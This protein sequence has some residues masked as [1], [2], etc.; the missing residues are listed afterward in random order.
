MG[1]GTRANTP[2]TRTRTRTHTYIHTYVH[3]RGSMALRK[4]AGL[5]V[6]VL[7]YSFCTGVGCRKSQ[8]G[9]R[10]GYTCHAAVPPSNLFL[11]HSCSN[12]NKAKDQPPTRMGMKSMS[13]TDSWNEEGRLRHLTCNAKKTKT[14]EQKNSM[15]QPVYIWSAGCLKSW[16]SASLDGLA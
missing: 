10:T 9:T 16:E 11:C 2:H 6:Y 15:Q 8:E 7:A 14:K 12:I 1:A 5:L 13:V 4:I 3:T